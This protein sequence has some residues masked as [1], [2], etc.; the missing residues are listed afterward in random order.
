MEET[1]QIIIVILIQEGKTENA[2]YFMDIQF[3]KHQPQDKSLWHNSPKRQL[4][5]EIIRC[6]H[7]LT[8]TVMNCF[9]WYKQDS[10][11][12]NQ[13]SE[14]KLW[15]T[16]Q[17]WGNELK[18]QKFFLDTFKSSTTF[19]KTTIMICTVTRLNQVVKV[20]KTQDDKNN[21]WHLSDFIYSIKTQ[22]FHS[23]F[24]QL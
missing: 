14:T 13:K 4:F 20:H 15:I 9:I 2:L 23:N 8:V 17:K 6:S 11:W 12:K 1:A 7:K 3:V 5:L 19:V 18:N 16:K 24:P 22:P 10:D 21:E